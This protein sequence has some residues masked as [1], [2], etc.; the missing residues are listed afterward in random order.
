MTVSCT[1]HSNKGRLLFFMIIMN[2]LNKK[3]RKGNQECTTKRH[4]K[5]WIQMKNKAQEIKA[6]S[7][8]HPTPPPRVT[9]IVKS[10][11]SLVGVGR[12]KTF[13]LKRNDQLFI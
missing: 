2:K 12:K 11:K 3:N 4:G 6:T 13:T 1:Y 9:H 7:D 10:D 5:R 8:T